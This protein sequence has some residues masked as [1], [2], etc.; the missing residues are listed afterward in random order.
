MT[1]HS[2]SA[3]ARRARNRRVA[4]LLAIG[5]LFAL[6][7][8]ALAV[9]AVL[10]HRAAAAKSDG[11]GVVRCQ[12]RDG[13]VTVNADDAS[14]PEIIESL[15]STLGFELRGDIPN[16]DLRITGTLEGRSD[17]LLAKLLQGSNYVLAIE[18]GAVKRL[19]MLPVAPPDQS[20]SADRLRQKEDELVAWIAQYEEFA[21][22][23]IERSRPELAKKFERHIK[24]LS[25][26]VEAVRARLRD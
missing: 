11:G 19:T 5:G 3:D 25:R 14:I 7:H 9:M 1:P 15:A 26:E 8:L 13:T 12:V 2:L 21:Q 6:T 4:P 10:P 22:E 24:E 17:Q 23:A 16:N 20:P 18:G